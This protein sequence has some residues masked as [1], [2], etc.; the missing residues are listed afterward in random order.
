MKSAAV[1][2]KLT[3][4]I[5][6]EVEKLQNGQIPEQI[7]KYLSLAYEQP[8]SLLDY[9]PDDGV[10]FFDEFSR[11]QEMSDS[12]EKEEAEWYTSLLQEGQIIH[13]IPVSHVFST[14]I[15][16]T[17]LP[18]VYFSLFLR[19]IPNTS[20][21]NIFNVSTK[22]MQNFH[23]QMNVLKAELDRWKKETTRLSCWDL[24]KNGSR[25][26]RGYSTT[27]R[28]KSHLWKTEISFCLARYR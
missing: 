13:D 4:Y 16:E 3:E 8:S 2:E 1:K 19:H 21:Q 17:E 10:I 22:P 7:F 28:L 18:K 5:G 15:G 14:L 11:V 27:I 12:L 26:S 9:L 24:M 6:H 20:P 25:S 23:G